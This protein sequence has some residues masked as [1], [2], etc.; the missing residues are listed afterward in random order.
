MTY[1]NRAQLANDTVGSRFEDDNG[2]GTW[3]ELATPNWAGRF[4]SDTNNNSSTNYVD[5][6]N[7]SYAL[8]YQGAVGPFTGSHDALLADSETCAVG[9]ILVDTGVAHASSVSDVITN[10]TRSTST[11]QKAVVGVFVKEIPN[12]VPVPLA[13]AV[14]TNVGTEPNIT[15]TTSY[16]IDPDHSS[17][18][19]NK[20]VIAMNSVGEGQVNVCGENGNIEI[21]DL[22]VSSSTTGKGM[23]QDDDIIRSCTVAKAR[24][25]VTFASASTVKQIACIYLCG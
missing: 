22:I 9:D 16:I 2:D 19:A 24:E 7:A 1:R 5:I 21:G 17:I 12:H 20:T 8:Y 11:S 13:K 4:A 14:T 15:T 25:A 3:C 18:V 6:A 23:K 10:V